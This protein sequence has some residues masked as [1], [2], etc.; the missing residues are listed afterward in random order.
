MNKSQKTIV[1]IAFLG[2]ASGSCVAQDDEDGPAGFTYATY[3]VC[4]VATQGD[5]D[6]VVE[7]TEKA[8][9]D[10]RVKDG[11]LLAWGYLSHFTGGRWRRAQYHVSPTMADALIAQAAIFSEIYGNGRNQQAGQT[12]AEACE[13]HD[14]YVWAVGQGSG[15]DTD[16]GDVSLSVYYVCDITREE[17]ADEI[18]AAGPG[19]KLDELQ[20]EGKIKSWGWSLH[21]IGGRFRRLQTI[22]GD[23]Y[24]SVVAARNDVLQHM[25]ENHSELGAEF[26][27]ICG[28]HT[29]YLWDIVHEAP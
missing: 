4:D 2:L 29:D 12:R 22:T 23:D 17:R 7:T 1:G 19:P 21:R 14:D 25:S 15:P 9:F 6:T 27:D 28:S 20:K 18:V 11:K 3:Y 8:V 26:T 5:M 13:A 16:R 10:K 24:A